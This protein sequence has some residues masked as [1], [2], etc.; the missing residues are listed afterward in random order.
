MSIARQIPQLKS[1]I[2]VNHTYRFINTNAATLNVNVT[3]L[4]GIV[5]TCCNQANATVCGLFNAFKVNRVTIYAAESV[6]GTPVTCSVEWFGFNNSPP[7]EDS[8]TSVSTAV[9]IVLSSKPPPNSLAKFWQTN[10]GT[11]LFTIVVPAGSVI[12]IDLDYM[13]ADTGA[14]FQNFAVTTGSAGAVYYL[15]LDN[16]AGTHNFAPVSK[17]TTF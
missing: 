7:I 11:T 9:P 4:M 12:D 6:A 3:S 13:L 17:V 2:R 16:Q 14:T 1:N 8:R 5:G 10:T 15:A